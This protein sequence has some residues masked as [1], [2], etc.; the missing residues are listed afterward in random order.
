MLSYR[1]A[2]HAGNHADVLKHLIFMLCVKHMNAKEKPYLLLDTHAGAGMYSL[3]CEQ[4]KRTGEFVDGVQRLWA[5]RAA[6]RKMPAAVADYLKLIE[7][8][9]GSPG[10]LR[11]YPGSP[12]LAMNLTREM[13]RL[14]FCELHSTDFAALRR[15]TK[16]V[17][18][19]TQIA[20]DDG[21]E[22][23]KAALPPISRRGLVLIDPSY[24][25]KSDYPRLLAAIKDAH[26]RFATGTYLIWH[27][28]LATLE[29][30][31]L[32]EKIKKSCGAEWLHA[33]LTVRAPSSQHGMHG[34]GMLI[35]NPPWTLRAALETTLPYLAEKLAQ[36]EGAAWSLHRSE[37]PQ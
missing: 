31:Q 26:K 4:A 13:D 35:V 25:M 32:P 11:H 5:E 19:R 30:H 18:H 33:S 22:A 21:F 24:E 15:L 9:N 2:F 6:Y 14:R 17:E 34:S 36:D 37:N 29:A 28:F 20:P 12:W 27:P 3:E 10:R 7:L 8:A 1:H 16:T 23:M